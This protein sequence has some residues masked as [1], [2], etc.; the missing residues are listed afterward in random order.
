MDT[1][2]KPIFIW[3]FRYYFHILR[4]SYLCS[5]WIIVFLPH[6]FFL[7]FSSSIAYISFLSFLTILL[8]ISFMYLTLSRFQLFLSSYPRHIRFVAALG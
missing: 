2:F 1:F 3:V 8:M 7:L 4:I 6:I 5:R